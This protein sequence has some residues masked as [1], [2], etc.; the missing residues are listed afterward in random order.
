MF[1]AE[2]PGMPKVRRNYSDAGTDTGESGVAGSAFLEVAK[3]LDATHKRLL[4]KPRFR[5]NGTT[6]VSKKRG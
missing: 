1:P 5:A 2:E 3:S 6:S 4:K